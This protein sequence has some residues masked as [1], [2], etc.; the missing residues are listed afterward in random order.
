MQRTVINK[1]K[2]YRVNVA[3][4]DGVGPSSDFGTLW[5]QSTDL[6]WYAVNV[7][8]SGLPATI[9][10][11]QTPL[12]WQS[13][14]GQDF[15]Y[16][17]LYC[18]DNGNVYKTYLSGS[19]GNVTMS[20]SQTPAP[21]NLDYKPYLLLKS[22]TDG[23]SYPVYAK[24]GSIYLFTDTNHPIFMNGG[25]TYHPLPIS[26][27][28]GTLIADKDGYYPIDIHIPNTS[29]WNI[30][31][32]GYGYVSV[33][34][35]NLLKN[36][37]ASNNNLS[38]PFINTILSSLVTGGLNSGSVYLTGS[39]N[40]YPTDLTNVTTL[41]NRHWNVSVNPTPITPLSGRL[42]ADADGYLPVDVNI[43]D[44][45]S[46]SVGYGGYT[47][48][49]ALNCPILSTLHCGGNNLS[50][51]ILTGATSLD[52]L[53]APNDYLSYIDLATNTALT[54]L[55]LSNNQ[56]TSI[57][58]SHNPILDY[59]AVDN[60]LFTTL[61]LPHNPILTGL[62]CNS[63][64]NLVSLD[65]SYNPLINGTLNFSNNL[66]LTTLN[67]SN[68]TGLGA[69]FT[70]DSGGLQNIQNLI[71]ENTQCVWIYAQ[72]NHLTNLDA[73]NNSQLTD[74]E[75]YSNNLTSLDVSND[76]AL[77]R[78]DCSDNQLTQTSIDGILASLVAHGLSG[79][80]V[81][82]AGG[83]NSPPTDLTNVTILRSRG[84]TVTT[85]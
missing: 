2:K 83:T 45:A 77:T 85:N 7:S 20:I 51:I 58:L 15:G 73:S 36:L 28:S 16:Q 65:L 71:L 79:G 52:Y 70:Y 53:D 69:T 19:A 50:S 72:L 10:I 34:G 30:S 48:I 18:A 32:G 13:I 55:V 11:N 61:S 9:Y 81:I 75:C 17:L 5:M 41:Q 54:Q 46:W 29:S 67:M 68:N 78:L 49:S 24:S 37:N 63:N 74:L 44:Q 39:N 40:G 64:P 60:N 27:I 59:L 56:F 33:Y 12:T 43:A 35:C 76:V 6:N 47:F 57:D 25:N 1:G 31:N 82:L 4:F 8:G 62:V 38:Q 3:D 66:S 80:T 22:I 23:F 26:P 42:M 14:G 21:S 84:W